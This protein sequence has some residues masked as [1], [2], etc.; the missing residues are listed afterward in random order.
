MSA[1]SK[2][3]RPEALLLRVIRAAE[4]LTQARATASAAPAPK[5][6][7]KHKRRVLQ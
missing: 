3:E 6:D 2:P 4:I 1:P 7:P 5:T